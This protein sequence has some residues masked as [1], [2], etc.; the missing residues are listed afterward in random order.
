MPKHWRA[1][2]AGGI[3]RGIAAGGIPLLSYGFRPFFLAAGEF[4]PLAMVLWLGTLIGGWEVGGSS[5]GPVAWHAHEMLFGYTSA[6]LTGFLL[7]T[8]PNWTG[9]LPVA[10]APL[11]TIVLLWLAGRVVMAAPDV[12]GQGASAVIDS[13]FLPVIL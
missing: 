3:P 5:Y 11:L 8:I 4:A 13:A 12:L 7:T 9:R 2:P 10:G 6:A 1:K